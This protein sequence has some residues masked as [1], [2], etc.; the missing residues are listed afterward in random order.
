MD[1]VAAKHNRREPMRS[2]RSVAEFLPPLRSVAQFHNRAPARCDLKCNNVCF[3]RCRSQAQRNRRGG[4]VDC[5]QSSDILARRQL[6]KSPSSAAPF[7]RRLRQN[8]GATP[9]AAPA[10]TGS[11]R[12]LSAAHPPDPVSMRASRLLS[13]NRRMIAY[14]DAPRVVCA[15]G[16]SEASPVSP[17][18]LGVRLPDD[19][20]GCARRILRTI[21]PYY[22]SSTHG[23]CNTDE[24][25]LSRTRV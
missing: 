24:A 12:G 3:R 15:W 17:R 13:E 5:M 10:R 25:Y 4:F 7:C 8:G 20:P 21:I 18:R 23:W 9:K 6:R 22:L 19:V 1:G 14:A 11:A 2:S 16:G